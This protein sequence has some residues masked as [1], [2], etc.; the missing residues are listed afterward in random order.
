[1]N[2]LPGLLKIDS[3]ARKQV[4]LKEKVIILLQIT[5]QALLTKFKTRPK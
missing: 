5:K 1:M 2:K 3:E 4:L